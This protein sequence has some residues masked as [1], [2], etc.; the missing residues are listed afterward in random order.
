MKATKHCTFCILQFIFVHFWVIF[1]NNH[2]GEKSSRLRFGCYIVPPAWSPKFRSAFCV[3]EKWWPWL[4]FVRLY[5][6]GEEERIAAFRSSQ[7]LVS[8]LVYTLGSP[9]DLGF[10][11]PWHPIQPSHSP[12]FLVQS[13]R[14]TVKSREEYLPVRWLTRQSDRYSGLLAQ[15]YK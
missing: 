8:T 14:N 6:S 15:Q 11:V 1:H 9:V 10:S 7:V 2:V 13:E 4:C 3:K 12:S 5:I